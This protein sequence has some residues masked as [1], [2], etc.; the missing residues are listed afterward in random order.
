VLLFK[1]KTRSYHSKSDWDDLLKGETETHQVSSDHNKL[2]DKSE[3]HSWAEKLK[4]A[5]LK[6]QAAV[7]GETA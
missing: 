1:G 3:V 7:V 6:A 5:L 4:P 2:R